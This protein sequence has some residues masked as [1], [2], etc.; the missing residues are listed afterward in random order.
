MKEVI[1]GLVVAIGY[2]DPAALAVLGT[3]RL[4]TI[5]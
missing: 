3:D 1:I 4:P 2:D 5:W